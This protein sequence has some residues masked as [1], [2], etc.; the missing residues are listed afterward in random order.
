MDEKNYT[1]I[2]PENTNGGHIHAE[3]IV[4]LH[5][6]PAARALFLLARNRLMDVNH[7]KEI[8]RLSLAEFRLT[9]SQGN[10]VSGP[11]Q[12]GMY[13]KIDVPGPGTETG[14]G[15]DWAV[16][17][18]ISEYSRDD[19]ESLGIRVRPAPNPTNDD[20]EIAHFYAEQATSTFTI[21]RENTKITAAVYDRNT[22]TNNQ[23][24]GFFDK[25][26]NAL[27]GTGGILAFSKIQWKSLTE[28][29]IKDNNA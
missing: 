10:E 17:E 15:F 13:F 21:T 20:Q 12:E 1:G 23:D 27:T 19:I 28:G 8:S 9:D 6:L 22:K 18:K 24:E 26:R 7:W 5:H 2:I 16:V 3:S 4:E 11:V 14:D 25:V 29:L